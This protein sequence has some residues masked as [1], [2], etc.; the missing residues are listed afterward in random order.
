MRKY[1]V[2]CVVNMDNSTAYVNFL[3]SSENMFTEAEV[4]RFVSWAQKEHPEYLSVS[5]LNIIPLEG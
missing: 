1:L 4:V 5:I 3:Y 2:V